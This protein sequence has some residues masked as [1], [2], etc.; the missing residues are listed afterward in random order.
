MNIGPQSMTAQLQ[1]LHRG[2][3]ARLCAADLDAIRLSDEQLLKTGAGRDILRPGAIAPDFTLHDQ[4]GGQ[5]RLTDRLA[6]GPV[7]L[8]FSRGGWCPFCTLQLR[9]WQSALWELHEAG[10]DLLAILPQQN[11]LCCT[12][13]ERDL[14]AYPVLSDP[15]SQVAA[16]YGVLT[17]VPKVVRPFYLRLGHEL[18]RI[19]GTDDWRIP[20]ASTVVVGQDGRIA[21]S[22]ADLAAPN[23][24]E[25]DRAL[26]A[27]RALS[28]PG[29]SGQD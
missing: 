25:P 20:L 14:L 1:A 10:G 7:V 29:E 2:M 19:N 11:A 15:G 27:V 21:L 8:L 6:H 28:R 24:M 12:T 18:P 16:Q 9:A 23:R 26:D 13:A 17:E 22:H 4:G 3:K 5:V